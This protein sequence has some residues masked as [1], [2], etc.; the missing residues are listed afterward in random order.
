MMNDKEYHCKYCG[1][2]YSEKNGD[3]S[4]DIDPYTKWEDLGED[5]KCPYCGAKKSIFS[6]LCLENKYGMRY[7]DMKV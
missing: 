2:V 6:L 3:P 4:I 1:Y 5:F 7:L